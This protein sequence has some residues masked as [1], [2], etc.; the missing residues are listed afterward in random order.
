MLRELIAEIRP[1]RLINYG[2]CG[3]LQADIPRFTT[4]LIHEIRMPKR[5]TISL[6][7]EQLPEIPNIFPS[8][9]LLTVAEPV[10]EQQVRETL[11]R[12][13]DSPVVDMEAYHIAEGV[14]SLGI[15]PII[16]K[17]VSDMA[18]ESAVA[19]VKRDKFI[20][21]EKLRERLSQLISI[22]QI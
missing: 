21:L 1:A 8:A 15:S 11:F 12:Q 13:T 6:P 20:L 22:L 10:L 4:Y 14:L 5:A 17:M 3:A 16:L 2:F 18:D 7:V 9:T 19:D